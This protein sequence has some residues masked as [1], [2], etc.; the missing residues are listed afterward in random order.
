MLVTNL[1]R[2]GLFVLLA[3]AVLFFVSSNSYTHDL[4]NRSDVSWFFMCGKAWM[5]GLIP[6]VDFAD[7]K[8]PLLWLI[9]G[10]GYL[11][12][13]YDYIGA[14]WISVLAYG[15]VVFNVFRTANIFLHD[16]RKSQ[17][18][19]VLMMLAFFWPWFHFEVKCED[20]CQPFVTASV[21]YVC[22]MLY[23][24]D[25]PLGRRTNKACF[26]LGISLAA[27][28]LIKFTITA[29][30]GLMSLYVLV[31][32]IRQRCNILLALL[33]GLAGFVLITLPFAAYMLYV[34]NFSAFIQEYFISTS[35]TLDSTNELS[36][37]F[38]EWVMTVLDGRLFGLFV[39]ACFGAYLMSKMVKTDKYFFLY[40]FMCFY[41][42][43]I[44]H[45]YL[46]ACSAFL[47]FLV[48]PILAKCQTIEKRK[49][50]AIV[51]ATYVATVFFH[52]FFLGYLMPTWWFRHNPGRTDFWNVAYLMSQV[53][54]PTVLNYMATEA[55]RGT[56]VN[57]LPAIKYWAWQTGATQEMRD[58]QEQAIRDQIAD[59]VFINDFEKGVDKR[60]S[61][62]RT[63]KYEKVY[64]F[65]LHQL[66]FSVYSKHPGLR[67]APADF[68]VSDMDI[69]LKRNM[70]KK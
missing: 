44:H 36:V 68:H 21:L 27:T 65:E 46:N 23:T 9:Y 26:V 17:L 32:I 15:V 66:N 69:L 29:M 50:R 37:Y 51:V 13:P 31:A 19:T 10:I 8:G 4:F 55:G 34:G 18:A 40:G 45:Y 5:N 14:F 30:L 3:F 43:A 16:D 28:L 42:I 57:A 64:D 20:W 2:Y 49:Y 39:A 25:E 6:Y 1:K 54:N 59:F 11:L 56:P 53:E 60:D 33:S 41:A 63:S 12:S 22:R 47:L 52:S 24:N 67:Q 58:Q 62:L 35:Q 38:R 70:F 48:V 7:S 61:L